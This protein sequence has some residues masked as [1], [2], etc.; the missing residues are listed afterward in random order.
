MS[1]AWAGI[2][3]LVALLPGVFFTIG[4]S[5]DERSTRESLERG[6]LTGVA[7]VLVVSL[8]VHGGLLL[9]A[10]FINAFVTAIPQFDLTHFLALLALDMSSAEVRVAADEVMKNSVMVLFYLALTCLLGFKL[11]R[12]AAARILSGEG[13][14]FGQ[15]AWTYDLVVGRDDRLTYAYVLTHIRDGKLILMYEGTLHSFGLQK[16]GR[17]SYIVLT[18]VHRSYMKLEEAGPTTSRIAERKRIGGSV[19]ATTAV[20]LGGG[21]EAQGTSVKYFVIEGEDIA[22]AYFE[23]VRV[24]DKDLSLEQLREIIARL[25]RLVS[26]S[27]PPEKGAT[28]TARKHSAEGRRG[29][30]PE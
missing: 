7:G 12:I 18:Q 10:Q 6:G 26:G 27:P 14:W 24:T 22:N 17:F 16:D 15:H 19:A 13:R 23:Q 1:L 4:L 8:L 20:S 29:T 21:K 28:S 25:E 5:V 3:L 9:V 30:R 2:L 11:G